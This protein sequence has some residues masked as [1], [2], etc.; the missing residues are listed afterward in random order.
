MCCSMPKSNTSGHIS[1]LMNQQM[2]A[3]I[4]LPPFSTYLPADPEFG[5][6]PD[7][8]AQAQSRLVTM[9]LRASTARQITSETQ[10]RTSVFTSVAIA[11][12]M[13]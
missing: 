7:P 5:L 12:W 11:A 10:M 4:P 3:P 2:P 1:L 8:E 13:Q 6:G 9:T